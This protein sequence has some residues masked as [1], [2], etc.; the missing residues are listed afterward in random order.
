[1]CGC[2]RVVVPRECCLQC[3]YLLGIIEDIEGGC[4]DACEASSSATA[5]GVSE[6]APLMIKAPLDANA[7]RAVLR[8]LR[9]ER[10]SAVLDWGRACVAEL[11]DEDVRKHESARKLEALVSALVASSYLSSPVAE[12]SISQHFAATIKETCVSGRD[13]RRACHLQQRVL[14]APDDAAYVRKLLVD[15]VAGASLL[16]RGHRSTKKE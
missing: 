11:L 7:L 4:E 13:V 8:I 14:L 6:C 1:M 2:E 9:G 3:A 15:G 10:V 16:R 5:G 12:D